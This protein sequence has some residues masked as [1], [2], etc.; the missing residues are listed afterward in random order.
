MGKNVSRGGSRFSCLHPT[1]SAQGTT[2]TEL[3]LA[4]L[5]RAFRGGVASSL[6]ELVCAGQGYQTRPFGLHLAL[7]VSAQRFAR[8]M[9]IGSAQGTT[10]TEALSPHVRAVCQS[11]WRL[12]CSPD[13]L[14]IFAC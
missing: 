11:R 3:R 12:E 1:G 7:P 9:P 14:L 8:L 2:P 5:F 13:I 6:D 10:P 4:L